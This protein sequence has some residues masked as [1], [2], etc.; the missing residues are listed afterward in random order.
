MA[1]ALCMTIGLLPMTAMAANTVTVTDYDSLQSALTSSADSTIVQ[2]SGDFSYSDTIITSKAL[3][4]D[5][6]GHTLTYTGTD[7]EKKLLMI[8]IR[9]TGT[10]MFTVKDSG[11]D[12]KFITSET[13][14]ATLSNAGSGIM[15]LSDGA[16]I[17]DK[18][19]AS[20][21]FNTGSGT[22]KLSGAAVKSAK[23]YAV[24]NQLT[25][26]WLN[27]SG[28]TVSTDS[29]S[30]LV[31]YGKAEISGGMVSAKTGIG[32]HNVG[33]GSALTVSGGTVESTSGQAIQNNGSG[34]TVTV[35]GGAVR[36]DSGFALVSNGKLKL[37]GGTASSGSG[38]SVCNLSGGNVTI[39]DG[40]TLSSTSG[41][42]VN[43]N[44]NLTM[45]GG[46]VSSDSGLALVSFAPSGSEVTVSGGTLSSTSSYCASN[47]AAG[48]MTISGTAVLN[49]G[50]TA[51]LLNQG[52]GTAVING[53]T[54]A[55]ATVELYNSG[56]GKIEINA[57]TFALAVNN[58]ASGGIV[59]NGGSIKAIQ[60]ATPKNSAGA[61]LSFYGIT[62]TD[63]KG[64]IVKNI[65]VTAS[66]LTLAT[67]ISYGLNGVKTDAG[68][69]VY[70]WLPSTATTAKYKTDKIDVSGSIASGKTSVLPNFTARVTV[71]VDGQTTDT[72]PSVTLSADNTTN[73]YFG[74]PDKTIIADKNGS[75]EKGGVYVFSGLDPNKTY[76]VWGK[77][78]IGYGYSGVE[79]KYEN[80]S[81]TVNYYSL[82]VSAG[83]GID[84]VF[85][86]ATQIQGT[87]A[88]VQADVTN[89]YS[90]VNWTN[91]SSGEE[92]LKSTNGSILLDGTKDITAHAVLNTYNGS[93][94]LNKNGTAWE[95]SGKV[96]TISPTNTSADTAGFKSVSDSTSGVYSFTSLSPLVTYYVWMDGA[97]TGQTV[98]PSGKDAVVDYYTVAVTS[99][100]NITDVVGG[101]V[102]LKGK[103]ITVAATVK[104]GDFVFGRW[105]NTTG[106]AL[107]SSA[108][109]Y[110]FTVNGAVSL[111]AVGGATKYTATVTL[112]KDGTDWASGPRKIVLSTS[113]TE[114]AGT[115]T[116]TVFGNT[117][118]FL[119]LPGTG[120]YYVWDADTVTYTGKEISS[121]AASIALEYYTVT[122][123]KGENVIAVTGAGEYLKDSKV[124]VSA[125]LS[126]YCRIDTEGW[127]GTSYTINNI[128][129]AE[130]ITA[131]AV[132]D[133]YTGTVNV[134]LDGSAYTAKTSD[135]TLSTSSADKTVGMLTVTGASGVFTYTNLDPR[136]TY[137]IWAG[138]VFTGRVLSRAAT[139]TIVDYYT[140]SVTK[141]NA[142]ADG[143]G[144]YLAGSKVTLTA[145]ANSGFEFLGWYSG[146]TPLSV[147]TTYTIDKLSSTQDI[148]AEASNV[149]TANVVVTGVTKSITLKNGGTTK[150]PDSGN[151]G[152]FSGLDRGLT[153]SVYADGADT[154]KTVSKSAPSITLKYYMVSLTAGPGI[155][156]VLG[157]GAYLE[158]SNVNISTSYDSG[159]TFN[160][161]NG[162][163]NFTE[164]SPTISSIDKDYLLTPSAYKPY[165]GVPFDIS[166]GSITV[167]DSG[168]TGKIKVE[169]QGQ[170]TIDNIDPAAAFTITGT[171]SNNVTIN[172]SRG[173][174]IILDSLNISVSGLQ[175][176]KAIDIVNGSGNVTLLLK[177]A[178]T[179]YAQNTGPNQYDGSVALCKS[180]TSSLTIQS[181][182][183]TVNHSLT[184][185]GEGICSAGIGNYMGT[186]VSNITINSGTIT[187][188][189]SGA[190]I[191]VYSMATSGIT[192]NGGKV[193]INSALGST[194]N[195]GS[196]SG[197]TLNG[198]TLSVYVNYSN[199]SSS[200][201]I[202]AGTTGNLVFNGGS[203]YLDPSQYKA[204]NVNGTGAYVNM[205]ALNTGLRNTD[206]SGKLT[207]TKQGDAG[208]SY[209]TKDIWTSNDPNGYVFA[210]LPDGTY[211]ATLGNK[212]ST[213]TVP[214]SLNNTLQPP[215]YSVNTP[216][217]VTT[218]GITASPRVSAYPSTSN[219]SAGDLVA[220]YV[221]L[222]GT[223]TK[224]GTYTVTV[225]G[226]GIDNLPQTIDVGTA[227]VSETKNF[228]F[229]MPASNITGLSITL[230]FAEKPKHTV[231]FKDGEELLASATYTEG[232]KYSLPD[233][234]VLKK[235]GYTFGGWG[236]TGEQTMGTSDVTRTAVWTPNTYKVVFH[237][238][239]TTTNQNFTYDAAAEAL[240]GSFIKT[241][242]TLSGWSA[243]AGGPKVYDIGASAQNLT[244]VNN[245]A[246]DLYAVWQAQTYTVSFANGS[247]TGTMS[248]QS[249]TH[250]VP[251]ELTPNAFTRTGY[252]FTGWKDSGSNDYYNGQSVSATANINLTAQW[253]ANSCTVVFYG[254]GANG[255]TPMASQ[256]FAYDESA[257]A[258]TVNTF[259]RTGYTFEGWALTSGGV[260]AYDNS[261]SVKNLTTTQNGTVTL[262]AVW[263]PNLYTVS[264]NAGTG[265]SGTM[266]IQ[267]HTYNTS[268]PLPENAFACLG[269]S[270]AGWNTNADGSGLSYAN[271][272]WVKNLTAVK[273][274]SVTL[275]AQWTADTYSLAFNANSGVGSM[276][277]QNF[278]TGD[279]GK[280]SDNRFVKPGYT[281]D[282]WNTKADGSGTNYAASAAL[283]TLDNLTGASPTLYA[284]WKANS[285]TV[286]FNS[287]GGTGNMGN[288][289]FT[290]DVAQKLPSIDFFRN[291]DTFLGWST[292]PT[293]ETATYTDEQSV[294]NLT[295][296][297]DGTVTLYAVW[298]AY[299]YEVRFEAN[300]G[301]GDMLPQTIGRSTATALN[302]NA[303]TRTDY[304]FAS[305]NTEANGSGL[306][307]A[308]GQE[309]TNLPGD[310]ASSIT[311]YAQWTE[312]ARFNLSG[313]V[314]DSDNK[315]LSGA[316]VTLTQGSDVIAQ[317]KTDANGAYFFGNLKSGTYN[318]V[319][320]KDG[321][322]VTVLM[323]ITAN[324]VKNVI[325]PTAATNNS[326]LVVTSEPKAEAPALT[327][328]G[329]DDLASTEKA[330]ITM[331]VTAK[332]EDKANA[333]QLAIIKESGG[334]T[335]GMYLDMTVKKGSDTLTSTANVLEIVIPFD[336]SGKTTVKVL[337]YHGSAAEELEQLKT[338]PADSFVDK[339]CYLDMKSG[340][341]HVYTSKFSTYAIAYTN[342]SSMTTYA[343]NITTAG[344]SGGSVKANR[345]MA[346]FG[347]KV[348]LTVT[349]DK[350][351]ELTGLSILD[352]SGKEITCTNNGDGTY[353]FTMPNSKATVTPTFGK[354]DSSFPFVDVPENHWAYDDIAWAYESGL[355]NGTGDGTSFEPSA[356]TTRGMIVTV[357]WR[358]EGKPAASAKATFLDVNDGAY[359]AEAI[360]WAAE[361]KIVEGFSPEA[362]KPEQDITRE[363]MAA[364][365]YRYA[366]YKGYDVSI[367]ESTN[368][369]SYFDAESVSDYAVPFVQ[370]ACGAGLINGSN[371][372]LMP[373]GNAERCQVAAILH[374]FSE[375]VAK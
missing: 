49:A 328:G 161:W 59:I 25:T 124:T 365:L 240:N 237:N 368:I 19:M 346:A 8:G 21:V 305:W 201:Y 352:A 188:S 182:D 166:K 71:K 50:G 115:V 168:S 121:S 304:T 147:S 370:W 348:T 92:V 123:V 271:K 87:Y 118:T 308:N 297:A 216:A 329:L 324:T 44:D 245:G 354:T 278:A 273:D 31:N 136:M 81:P 42:T 275:Y 307:Y 302:A 214:D 213:F 63:G 253:I 279:S 226:A 39:S 224:A 36:T 26:G 342:Y 277:Y 117:Y 208:F 256:S 323:T 239:A 235:T 200:G 73:N 244:D 107:V 173:A 215:T 103:E 102:F 119:N 258:L 159:Y 212:S 185:T 280:V 357:L 101:G 358:M 317:T 255:G 341:I 129:K 143:G 155:I 148:T 171:S 234:S 219:I 207:I 153:Y 76:Y 32:A 371:D 106:G 330:N 217:S 72:P 17:A 154:G 43:N 294:S 355:M 269:Y 319:A 11:T 301:V 205:V 30:A 20:C 40:A 334:N 4:L 221:D 68:G 289:S 187:A 274:A 310:T 267:N 252:T 349:L 320:T 56:T 47:N 313:A 189:G 190:S 108:N 93:V 311:L 120:N 65:P 325:I 211:T 228:Y 156:S 321:K 350:G 70:L 169:Q 326:V 366:K 231:S 260:K 218:A 111:T 225:T 236:V 229:N 183:G 181:I 89:G 356:S 112:K 91:T 13:Y 241:G 180:G 48:K 343:V 309:V 291:G 142:S 58:N 204:S 127:T 232:E 9:F 195:K 233:G 314:K 100:T 146:S 242:Y 197:F 90:F 292:S 174:T 113:Q 222:S 331:T 150:I 249:F 82:K 158:G 284:K 300:G 230:S 288:Q 290:Y 77:A 191:G 287:N 322:T 296:M 276:D 254:N 178:N 283:M 210:W 163:A 165:T 345:T 84:C 97:Y 344:V 170:T 86:N 351:F 88:G 247:G 18:E 138:D 157:S 41:T 141:T 152:S 14:S 336:F 374:R 282:G 332:A 116:G 2:L 61:T 164:A 151:S 369:L 299:T 6:N 179:L 133:T 98:T 99:G 246:V 339:T 375:Q 373:Q 340:S 16:I 367:G 220:V 281:F 145:A 135:I 359:Y 194:E 193:T 38:V 364:I 5:L 303:Y 140:V 23:F 203:L 35:T 29:S 162:T 362:F 160:G 263:T 114:L 60:G 327:V 243:S 51:C 1:L 78:Q 53:G 128:T 132:L 318:L 315:L 223:P 266:S 104:T 209:G 337:R 149:Y 110:T 69:T 176:M 272:A 270:F 250:G 139:T 22:I 259:T 28:G 306:S 257:K 94:T 109:P 186:D 105:Q 184:A 95:G 192:I 24:I 57:G 298:R 251:Q 96:V 37:S 67:A 83:E 122:V 52:A 248:P 312:N 316:S 15:E 175:H 10:G 172:A 202:G 130:A 238:D 3:T 363:Q 206:V 198:G 75:P 131:V 333:E 360:A 12:G 54:L 64:S 34:N 167:S 262:Y 80:S 264:F 33:S 265:G 85:M 227:A 45:T 199:P 125:T 285:Y 196:L 353:T 144:V 126:D 286:A 261:A 137:Y 62:L 361:Y 27:M 7:T 295:A 177:E 347:E 79:L 293:A 268:L 335:V 66:E 134:K 55:A 372:K 46:T 338:M 74:A